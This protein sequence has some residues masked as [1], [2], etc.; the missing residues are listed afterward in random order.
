MKKM[1]KTDNRKTPEDQ[2]K[3]QSFRRAMESYLKGE[4]LSR[5]EW[6]MLNLL[7]R[8]EQDK[9]KKMDERG[10][11]EVS[12]AV[13]A[14][15]EKKIIAGHPEK[16]RPQEIMRRF[17]LSYRSVAAFCIVLLGIGLLI[18][19]QV[20]QHSAP[21]IVRFAAG[22]QLKKILLSDS[23]VVFLNVGS[24]LTLD[25]KTFNTDKRRVT[26]A[27]EA[28]F[29]VKKNPGKPFL[30]DGGE[31]LATVR[32]TS[33][34][35][36]AYPGAKEN[37]VSVRDGIVDV[38]EK[39]N[40]QLLATLARDQQISWDTRENTGHTGQIGWEQ[41][42]GWIDGKNLVLNSAGPDEIM[43][44]FRSYYRKELTL[45]SPALRSIRLRGTFPAND[46][47]EALIGRMC[48]IYAMKCD[49]VSRPGSV[50][51]YQ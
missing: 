12:R 24:T 10:A 16:E 32:G 37:V 2:K 46:G 51:L 9:S 35:V 38:A 17:R 40:G 42:G 50:I 36:K 20:R 39:E 15:V 7:I 14:R 48:D 45:K 6:T 34:D 47:G 5:E 27:G 43:L 13:W 4:K 18:A 28:F 49:S 41:A 26:L 22:N 1:K 8:E 21:D 11:R 30:V 33:F 23:S 29:E 3:L 19:W 25:A 44:K 31:L